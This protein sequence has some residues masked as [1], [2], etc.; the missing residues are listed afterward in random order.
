MWA[1]VTQVSDSAQ[2]IEFEDIPNSRSDRDYNDV[3]IAVEKVNCG[4]DSKW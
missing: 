1:R 2:L 3:V 4:D